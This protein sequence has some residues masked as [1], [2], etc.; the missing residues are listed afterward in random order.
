MSYLSK[1]MENY[2]TVAVYGNKKSKTV[3]LCWGSNKGVCV[4]AAEGL[5]LKVIQPRVFS[6]FPLKQLK[7]ALVGVKKIIAVESNATA[8]LVRMLA[9]YGFTVNETILKYNGRPF[10]L[11]ELAEL[12]RGVIK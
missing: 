6:P 3:V 11:E 2:E 4:E 1:D 9:G 10:A 5:G 7:E 12:L 8:Q